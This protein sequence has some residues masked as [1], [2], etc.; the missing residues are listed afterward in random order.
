MR[1]AHA[2]HNEELCDFLL[3]T[4]KY[5]DWVVTTAF[6]AALNFVKFEMFPLNLPGIGKFEDFE[7]YLKKSGKGGEKHEILK[8]LVHKNMKCGGAYRWLLENCMTARYNEYV[9]SEQNAKHAKKM[10]AAVKSH[11]KKLNPVGKQV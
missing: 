11:C 5:N 2:E 10:L 1:K 7:S 6:Y 4:K 9:V 3:E 8:Q